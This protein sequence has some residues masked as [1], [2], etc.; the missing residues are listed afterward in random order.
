[1]QS[2]LERDSVFTLCVRRHSFVVSASTSTTMKEE[3][4]SPVQCLLPSRETSLNTFPRTS[5][6]HK[7]IHTHQITPPRP[8]FHCFRYRL[9]YALDGCIRPR[10]LPDTSSVLFPIVHVELVGLRLRG[11]LR[12]RFIEKVLYTNEQLLDGNRRSPAFFLVENRKTDC[13]TRVHIWVKERWCEFD[14]GGLARV[15]FGKFH[16]DFE[17]PSFPGVYEKEVSAI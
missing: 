14:F 8:Y 4:P 13:S 7:H 2:I 5:Q 6:T 12:I 11:R 10:F 15:L 1:M 17:H 9:V 16:G 3:S